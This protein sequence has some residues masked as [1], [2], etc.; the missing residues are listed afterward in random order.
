MVT[1]FSLLNRNSSL[2]LNDSKPITGSDI[3][4]VQK[5]TNFPRFTMDSVANGVFESLENLQG[6]R[7]TYWTSSVRYFESMEHVVASAYDIVD[8]YL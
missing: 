8:R 3:I 5:W 1:S 6:Y 7:K 2:P 4:K